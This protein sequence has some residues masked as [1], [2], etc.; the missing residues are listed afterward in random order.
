M[1]EIL[2]L[3]HESV[4]YNYLKT[5]GYTR[6]FES[7]LREWKAHNFLYKIGYKRERTGSVDINQNEPLWRKII[8]AVLSLFV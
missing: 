4:G 2:Q 5:A 8:Y 3:I 7:E 6:T 1:R